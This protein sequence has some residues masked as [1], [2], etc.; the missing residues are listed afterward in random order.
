MEY[1]V[2]SDD[3]LAAQLT[4]SDS[5]PALRRPKTLRVGGYTMEMLSGA[6]RW[7]G[8]SLKLSLDERELLGVMLERAGQILSC[9]RLAAM[10]STTTEKVEAR[11]A[12]LRETLLAEG[13]TWLPRKVSGCG[14]ILWR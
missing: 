2:R 10:M 3:V 6:V 12:T 9:E 5:A 1:A 4:L 7:R 13:V 14:Y 11:L 8:E